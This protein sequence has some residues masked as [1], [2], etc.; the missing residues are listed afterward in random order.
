VIKYKIEVVTM[1]VKAI[2]KALE[3]MDKKYCT[4]SQI[5]YSR[6]KMSESNKKCLRK[7]KYLE[8]PFAYEF[9]R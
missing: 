6:I 9:Y 4:L 7:E 1:V 3:N 5:D 2:K 8:R